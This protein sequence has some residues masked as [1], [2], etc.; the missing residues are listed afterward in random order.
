MRTTRLILRLLFVVLGSSRIADAATLTPV[1]AAS[2]TTVQGT[3]GLQEL[4]KLKS[5]TN[6]AWISRCVSE[7]R[8]SPVMCSI[9]QTLVLANTNQTV[10]SVSVQTQSDTKEQT[11]TIR[12]PVGIYLPAG[13]NVQ[14]DDSKP[15]LATLQ[16]CDGQGCYADMQ[17]NS[18]TVAALKRGKQLSLII[19]N[20]A[21]TKIT[22]PLPLDT[23][24]Q[25]LQK[26]Q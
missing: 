11:M 2:P 17:L 7:S 20:L 9:E 22:L 10:A 1:P 26:I 5:Q 16:T 18:D 25:A 21:K 3:E 19:E 13:L 4:P 23:F 14:I 6:P 12:V 8:K 15:L 24:A